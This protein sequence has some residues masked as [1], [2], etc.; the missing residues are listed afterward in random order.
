MVVGTTNYV[1]GID[2][3]IRRCGRFDLR[4]PVLPPAQQDR[5]EIFSYY[6][7]RVALEMFRVGEVIEP[8]ALAA[9]TLCSPADIKT[10]VELTLRRALFA[11]GQHS[12]GSPPPTDDGGY[13]RDHSPASARSKED[14]FWWITGKQAKM[15]LGANDDGL[16]W[17]RR[18]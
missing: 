6:L 10:V 18:R 3:A 14:A 9:K 1:R 4:V 7:Q 17:L 8:Q 12:D 16:R 15:D 5:E 2:T 13:A 11:A